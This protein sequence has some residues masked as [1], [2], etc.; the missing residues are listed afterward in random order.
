M[1]MSHRTISSIA[2]L[3]LLALV[4]VGIFLTPASAQR[5]RGGFGRDGEPA[6]DPG[7]PAGM[8]PLSVDLFA[9][10]NF[11]FDRAYWTDPRY[12]RCNT[13][14]QLTDMWRNGRFGFWGDCN[15]D[16]DI[17]DI[18][19]PHPYQTAEEHYNALMADASWSKAE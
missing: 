17:A 18:A 8:E 5:G 1:G 7:P 13:P 19:S 3:M 10:E 4:A 2:G 11:Y 12:T 6:V 14:R 16:R 15:L 9:T